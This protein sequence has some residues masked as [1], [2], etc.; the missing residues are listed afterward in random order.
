MTNR[1]NNAAMFGTNGFVKAGIMRD[2]VLGVQ[3]FG[4]SFWEIL[5]LKK[6]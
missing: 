5:R 2:W 4:G 3:A 6:P 1:A